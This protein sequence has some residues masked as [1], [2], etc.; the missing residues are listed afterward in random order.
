L[1]W[2]LIYKEKKKRYRVFNTEVNDS[3]N[4]DFFFKFEKKKKIND[5]IAVLFK[6]TVSKIL[7]SK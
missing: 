4:D 5:E 6:K 1:Y 7:K 2:K 3:N